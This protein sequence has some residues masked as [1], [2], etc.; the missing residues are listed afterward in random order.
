M[1][2]NYNAITFI[3]FYCLLYNEKNERFNVN[4]QPAKRFTLHV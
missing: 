3:L 1:T 2:D 4:P